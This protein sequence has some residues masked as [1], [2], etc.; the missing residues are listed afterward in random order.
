[1]LNNMSDY[2]KTNIKAIVFLFFFLLITSFI[3]AVLWTLI[4]IGIIIYYINSWAPNSTSIHCKHSSSFSK[5]RYENYIV[6]D[7][8]KAR[9]KEILAR[10]N[11][12]CKQCGSHDYLQVHH[13]NYKRLEYELDSDLV[14]VCQECHKRIHKHY[15]KNAKF[16]PLLNKYKT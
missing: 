8:W 3:P 15:G 16:Y 9:R 13:I 7:K 6:S 11:Y 14:S 10:D 2:D 4:I 12:T 1:M 5:A